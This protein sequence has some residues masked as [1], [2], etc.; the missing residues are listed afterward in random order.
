MKK[1]EVIDTEG[2]AREAWSGLD[3]IK[4]DARGDRTWYVT[5]LEAAPYKVSGACYSFAHALNTSNKYVDAIQ[6]VGE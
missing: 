1:I 6:L 2:K 3:E 4:P 5:K